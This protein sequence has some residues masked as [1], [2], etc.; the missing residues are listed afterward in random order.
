[1]GY[2]KPENAVV[3]ETTVISGVQLDINTPATDEIGR[4]TWNKVDKTANLKLNDEVILQLGQE[5]LIYCY[6]DSDDISNG[7]VVYV[8]GIF[9][10]KPSISLAKAD[11]LA[12][13]EI[14]GVATQNIFGGGYGFVTISGLVRNLNTSAFALGDTLY[15]SASV[16]GGITKVKPTSPNYIRTIGKAISID[17]TTGTIL[18]KIEQGAVMD[19]EQIFEDML[20]PNGFPDSQRANVG[21]SYNATTR[22][23]TVTGTFFYYNLGIKYIKNA[24]TEEVT[25]ADTIGGYFIYYVG[26]TLTL[27]TSAWDLIQHV[28]VCFVTYNNTGATTFWAGKQGIV[29]DERHGI[30]MD[31]RSHEEFHRKI[32][33]YASETG[34]ALNGTYSVATGT[35]GLI[36]NSFGVDGGTIY[37]EDLATT[38]AIL[39]DNAGVGNQ[40]PIFYRVGSGSEWRWYVNN[41]PYLFSGT[42]IVYNQLTGGSYQTTAISTNGRFVNYYIC[43]TPELSGT[44]RFIIIMGQVEHTSLANAQAESFINLD[45]TGFPSQEVAPLWQIT[46][47]RQSSYDDNGNCRIE[48][49]RKIVGTSSAIFTS[50]ASDHNTLANRATAN[51]HPALS[52]ATDTANFNG[53]LTA[54]EDTVQK[55]L[56]KLDDG[57]MNKVTPTTSGTLNPVNSDN[58]L[59]EFLKTENY[60]TAGG[61]GD[62]KWSHYARDNGANQI[63]VAKLITNTISAGASDYKLDWVFYCRNGATLNEVLRIAYDGNVLANSVNITAK[64]VVGSEVAL[65]EYIDGNQI[66]CKVINFGAVPNN[67]TKNVA[68][69]I[70]NF[71]RTKIVRMTGSAYDGTKFVPF[72]LDSTTAANQITW[73]IDSTNLTAATVADRSGYTANRIYIYYYK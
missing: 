10:G 56:D 48:S 38:I 49:T 52:I 59:Y 25:H 29:Y 32:G 2:T 4:F 58:I 3:N 26:S 65:N 8:S 66:Y 69:G 20:N 17:A 21:I 11:A 67:T 57:A 46:F 22:K 64:N 39:N 68:H 1:M 70:S 31:G 73:Q 37:D 43:A 51:Q 15:L 14:I 60:N 62:V 44:Y 35:G 27:S 36:A 34:F 12:T 9:S 7:Q 71:D 24:V 28:P 53:I 23:I 63:E 42:D 6:N 40:Y 55:A 16:L 72:G 5:Q 41:L 54:T 33:C 61:G 18:V 19:A 13:S 47:Q 50:S 30:I 45:R